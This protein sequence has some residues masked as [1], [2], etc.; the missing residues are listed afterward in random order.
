MKLTIVN[1]NSLVLYPGLIGSINTSLLGYT[2]I[3]IIINLIILVVDTGGYLSIL[4]YRNEEKMKTIFVQIASYRD[5]ELLPTLRDLFLK[6]SGK[7]GIHV[8]LVWQKDDS[9]SLE[10]FTNDNR[11]R[12]LTYK[13]QDSKGLGWARNKVQTLYNNEDYTLQLDSH[14]R[15]AQDWDSKLVDML[16]ELKKTSKKPL[17]TAPPAGYDPKNDKVLVPH[18]CVTL[19]VDFK[20]GGTILFN[21]VVISVGGENAPPR[22]IRARFISGGFYFTIGDHCKEFIY[23]PNTYFAGDEIALSVRSYTLGYDL[24]HPN[25]NYIWHYYGRNDQPKHWGD[26]N[27]SARDTGIV[28]DIWFNL[29]SYSKK[30][31]RKL[32]GENNDVDL[33][34]YSLG[35]ERSLEDY[36]KYAGIDFN[37]KRIQKSA[38]RGVEPPVNFKDDN[39]YEKDFNKIFTLNLAANWDKKCFLEHEKDLVETIVVN[40]ISLRKDVIFSENIDKNLLLQNNEYKKQ[41]EL[42]N[43]PVRI[44]FVGKNSSDQIICETSFDLKDKISWF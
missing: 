22:P 31:I 8:G 34:I 43:E 37:K 39:D 13:W 32:L 30:R 17:L 20:Q 9:E 3:N 28:E 25:E 6:S 40:Y 4:L 5:V 12:I 14:H 23:D 10:E 16:E 27:N 33:G 24:Y 35:S 18:I 7:Y 2:K 21:P 41:I 15:F 19:P 1:Q 38:I 42:N 26:H 11:L 36:G 44:H 29:D